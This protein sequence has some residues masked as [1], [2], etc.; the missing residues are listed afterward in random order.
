MRVNYFF[1]SDLH[2]EHRSVI[3]FTESQYALLPK[4]G[5]MV[6]FDGKEWVLPPDIPRSTDQWKDR[7]CSNWNRVV[8]RSDIVYICGDITYRNKPEVAVKYLNSL[9]GTKRIVYG[10]HDSELIK[11]LT[12]NPQNGIELVGSYVDTYIPMSR[13]RSAEHVI[14]S[15]CP[16]FSYDG[17]GRGNIHIFGHIHVSP[18]ENKAY[19]DSMRAA[20]GHLDPG[21]LFVNVGAMLPWMNFCPRT[22][23]ELM[24]TML[25][26]RGPKL[27]APSG[28]LRFRDL[29]SVAGSGK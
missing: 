24:P 19:I 22:L 12:K 8:G 9:F 17:C 13:G 28:Q 3:P 11:Y 27:E 5:N 20:F 29:G 6:S 2:I 18:A 10:N 14:M 25:M 23:D 1:I 15:H 7:I 21:P 26:N 16:I 4:N